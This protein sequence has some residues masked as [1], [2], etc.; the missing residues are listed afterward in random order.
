MVVRVVGKRRERLDDKG[1]YRKTARLINEKPNHK[2]ELLTSSG[3][4]WL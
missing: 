1:A 3:S 2:R 4:E